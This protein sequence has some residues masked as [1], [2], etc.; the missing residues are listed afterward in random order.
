M[1]LNFFPSDLPGAWLR[2]FQVTNAA[3]QQPSGAVLSRQCPQLLRAQSGH[4]NLGGALGT[5][6]TR[7]SAIFHQTITDQPASHYWPFQ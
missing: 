4:G 3:G 6:V 5:C 1:S 7:L 2:S